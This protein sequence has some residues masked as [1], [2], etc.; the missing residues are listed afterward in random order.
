MTIKSLKTF[1]G[2]T[3]ELLAHYSRKFTVRK[4]DLGNVALWARNGESQF[5]NFVLSYQE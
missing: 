2:E 4:P 1:N 3:S 5:R